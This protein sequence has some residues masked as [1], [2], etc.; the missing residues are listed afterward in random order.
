MN[1][2]KTG[3]SSASSN[4]ALR[5][6]RCYA[7]LIDSGGGSAVRCVR[8]AATLGRWPHNSDG[9]QTLSRLR[10]KA[11]IA[12]MKATNDRTGAM[13]LE[14]CKLLKSSAPTSSIGSAVYR[15]PIA[16]GQLRPAG[17]FLKSPG[18]A[19]RGVG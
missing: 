3:A 12:P 8:T 10:A 18:A 6:S 15:H 9:P 17:R 4:I 16:G 7:K 14:I 19:R 11:T 13:T 5:L 2:I 1:A